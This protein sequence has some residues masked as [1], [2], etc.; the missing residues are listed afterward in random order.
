[1]EPMKTVFTIQVMFLTASTRNLSLVGLG[2]GTHTGPGSVLQVLPDVVLK[3]QTVE[4]V[5]GILDLDVLGK[6]VAEYAD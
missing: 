6:A 3:L 2:A 1:M 4:P 5:N